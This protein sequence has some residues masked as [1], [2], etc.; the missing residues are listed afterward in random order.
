MRLS[1]RQLGLGFLAAAPFG[2]PVPARAENLNDIPNVFISPCG[3][4]FRAKTGAPY[5]VADW[6]HQANTSKTGKL[7]RVEFVADAGAFFKLL[8]RNGDGFLSPPEV[9]I[10]EHL[11]CPEVLGLRVLLDASA[12]EPQPRLWWAQ[13]SPYGPDSGAGGGYGQQYGGGVYEGDP[14]GTV[15]PSGETAPNSTDQPKH[16]DES[17]EGASPYS[18]FDE[19][20]PVMAADLDFTGLISRANFLKVADTHFTTLDHDNVGWLRLETLPET[21]VEKRINRI[22]A[23]RR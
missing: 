9:A 21:P 6:F 13:Y 22:L 4:P 10:Y 1:R 23:K 8:D 7:T 5:P 12:A 11:I 3:K 20:E 15:D 16:L 18:F 2:L 17:G 19:P 14:M